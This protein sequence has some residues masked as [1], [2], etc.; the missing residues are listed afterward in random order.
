M[1]HPLTVILFF[2]NCCDFG[3]KFGN[4]KR[5]SP[6]SEAIYS[7]SILVGLNPKT[8]CFGIFSSR[9]FFL[10]SVFDDD[11]FMTKVPSFTCM[12]FSCS[13]RTS[14][15]LLTPSNCTAIIAQFRKSVGCFL[16]FRHVKIFCKSS[17][18]KTGVVLVSS[19]LAAGRRLIAWINPSINGVLNA[20]GAQSLSRWI[21]FA[22]AILCFRA[23]SD[24]AVGCKY[25]IIL[26]GE[27]RGH[28]VLFPVC[29]YAF[30]VRGAREASDIS[31]TV[32]SQV[33]LPSGEVGI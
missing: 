33:S 28:S 13:D 10:L 14:L 31:L 24:G 9:P 25:C 29:S 6:L 7:T 11:T 16:S 4:R 22:V 2:R 17:L 18:L 12:S 1:F 23:E 3:S 27:S 15:A 5:L 30:I 19:E 8:D 20:G 32:W 21:L 26:Y